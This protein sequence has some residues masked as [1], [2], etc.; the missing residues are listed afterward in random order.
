MSLDLLVLVPTV[1]EARAIFGDAPADD[2]I[3][4]LASDGGA[5]LAI[6][7]F[8]PAA[9]GA[10]SA[11]LIAQSGCRR[12]LLIGLAGTF[13]EGRAPLGA[14]LAVARVISWGIGAGEGAA[15]VGAAALGFPQ[16]PGA[17]DDAL[18]LD[19]AGESDLFA[20]DAGMLADSSV[21][22]LSAAAAA[23]SAQEAAIRRR[24]RPEALIEDLESWAVALAF[25]EAGVPLAIRR[26]VSNRVGDRDA[27]HWRSD[28]AF[29]RLRAIPT[30]LPSS[31]RA[32]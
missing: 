2:A 14:L 22:A 3:A 4:P 9:A 24:H 19:R 16:I 1:L 15:H 18:D 6:C 26:A 27:R 8:G 30:A 5:G 32:R 23:A 28:A 13:D 17:E 12:G 25:H 10:R 11:R 7:G 20:S 21:T 31:R 29:A